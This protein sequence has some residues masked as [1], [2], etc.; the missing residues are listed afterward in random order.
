MR[1]ATNPQY[2]HQLRL[3]ISGCSFHGR[4]DEYCGLC[5][6]SSRISYTTWSVE[7][8]D[9]VSPMMSYFTAALIKFSTLLGSYFLGETLNVIGKVGCVACLQGSILLVLHAPA[10]KHIETVDEI[11]HLAI[12]PCKGPLAAL[13]DESTDIALVFVFY[14]VGVAT[15]AGYLIW[16]VAPVHG[17][18]NPLVYLS[19]CS[20]VGSLSVMS[21]KAVG[22]AVKL[23]AGGKNQ[24]THPSTYFFILVLI[25]ATLTQMNYLNKAM[26]E[27]PA[28][29]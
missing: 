12:Q 29:L 1:M 2:V 23:T 8:V 9:Q 5:I 19:I 21:D 10:D 25:V 20:S 27:F 3:M 17:R 7:R 4:D 26:S 18:K 15:V 6:R 22:I 24:F 14:F 28:S 16:K 13:C 11:L